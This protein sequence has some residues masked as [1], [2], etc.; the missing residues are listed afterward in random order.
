MKPTCG[1]N[2][3]WTVLL[4]SILLSLPLSHTAATRR[5]P[6]GHYFPRDSLLDECFPCTVQC[7]ANEIIR[8]PCTIHEDTQCGPFTEFK[9]FNTY[10]G[11]V[12]DFKLPSGLLDDLTGTADPD[13]VPSEEGYETESA[14]YQQ[15][16][17]DVIA[18]SNQSGEY[19]GCQENRVLIKGYLIQ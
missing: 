19:S 6:P 11:Q 5:C 10:K 15:E 4:P 7:P 8:R 17:D 16:G 9:N 2:L 14:G 18:T 13:L 3:L 12:L 1:V